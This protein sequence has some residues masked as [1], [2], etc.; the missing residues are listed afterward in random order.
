MVSDK[1]ELLGLVD[2]ANDIY[3]VMKESHGNF[4]DGTGYA[5]AAVM[6]AGKITDPESIFEEA[7][8]CCGILEETWGRSADIEALSL[9]LATDNASADF[10]CARFREIFRGLEEGGVRFKGTDEMPVLGC[11]SLLNMTNSEIARNL[12]EADA[13]LREQKGFGIMS[14][15]ADRRHMYA[16]LLVEATYSATALAFGIATSIV[17]EDAFRARFAA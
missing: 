3:A 6:A 14:C 10:K 16:A 1:E 2:A 7:E 9:V 5:T 13:Y 4:A 17:L 11:L 15:R 8:K 12:S